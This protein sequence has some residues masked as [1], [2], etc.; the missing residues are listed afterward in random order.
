MANSGDEG[1]VGASSLA[2]SIAPPM[3][4]GTKGM[5]VATSNYTM[6]HLAPA[7]GFDN[8]S[9]NMDKFAGH[10]AAAHGNHHYYGSEGN[11]SYGHHGAAVESK[12]TSGQLYAAPYLY[13]HPSMAYGSGGTNG[14]AGGGYDPSNNNMVGGGGGVAFVPQQPRSE[15]KDPGKS[16]SHSLRWWV[17]SELNLMIVVQ[18]EC[19]IVDSAVGAI[20]SQRMPSPCHPTTAARVPAPAAGQQLAGP[21]LPMRSHLQRKGPF[22]SC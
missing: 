17:G 10:G 20:L 1:T 5:P 19:L 16:S 6:P 3:Q 18:M 7:K 9:N 13:D 4:H 12:D 21:F 2:S 11:P 22:V 8:G 14:P 15:A